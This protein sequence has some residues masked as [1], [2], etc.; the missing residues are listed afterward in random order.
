M[1][2]YVFGVIGA[3][4]S[5]EAPHVLID[6]SLDIDEDTVSNN[7]IYLV[8]TANNS[9]I[10]CEYEV[11]GR[12]VSLTAKGELLPNENYTLI[13]D[14]TVSSITGT[15]IGTAL[16]KKVVFKS[17]VTSKV[18]VLSP[19]DFQEIND[20][21]LEISWEETGANP[22]G[23]YYLEIGTDNA[24]HNTICKTYISEKAFNV[25]DSIVSEPGEYYIRV[26]AH[27][28]DKDYGAWSP[29]VSFVVPKPTNVPPPEPVE[30]D[31]DDG[32]EIIDLVKDS[33][34]HENVSTGNNAT[35]ITP[36]EITGAANDSVT[37]ISGYK[38]KSPEEFTI[39][40][41]FEVD[42]TDLKILVKRGDI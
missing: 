20:E 15:Q 6:F 17:T 13:I 19:S 41:P 22:I 42:I 23:K 9:A 35:V 8:R 32:P 27:N 25:S 37:F 12:R 14:S 29:T 10:L 30:P 24:F 34:A 7:S 4:T 11:D 36:D 39:S 33:I 3:K 21:G 26:R 18:T 38:E 5:L 28:N 1:A 40:F 2:E 31:I 16:Y